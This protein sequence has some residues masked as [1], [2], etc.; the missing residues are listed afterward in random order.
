MEVLVE[1]LGKVDGME[2]FIVQLDKVF[3]CDDK[4]KVYEVYKNFDVFKI[5]ENMNIF[6]YIFEFDKFYNKVK[7]YEMVFFEVIFVFKILD[8]VGFFL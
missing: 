8:N 7:K 3:F 2:K 6:D 1:D 4:D 5:I